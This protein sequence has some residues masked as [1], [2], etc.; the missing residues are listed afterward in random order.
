VVA[1]DAQGLRSPVRVFSP[2][3]YLAGD[4]EHGA[5]FELDDGHEQRALYVVEGAVGIGDQR[6]ERH[7][8]A[9][10]PAKGRVRMN[11]NAGARVVIF[12]GAALDAPRHLWWNFVSSSR[13]RIEQA[14]RDW[15]E[16]RFGLIPGDDQEFISLPEN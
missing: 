1:G 8:L 11:A 16:G 2:T 14:K 12:G 10:L 15:V 4:M 7:T 9:V 5:T 6:V 13:E 3:L